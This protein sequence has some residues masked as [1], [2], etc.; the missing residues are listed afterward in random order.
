MLLVGLFHFLEGFHG[1]QEARTMKQQ[2][3][4]ELKELELE[5][6]RLKVRIEKLKTDAFTKEQLVREKLGYVKPG[7]TVYKI[8]RSSQKPTSENLMPLHSTS[9]VGEVSGEM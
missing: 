5:H 7:E 3:L 9:Q 6:D 8:A 4:E 1:W 2:Y